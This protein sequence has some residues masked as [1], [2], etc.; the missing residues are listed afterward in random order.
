[1]KNLLII[2]LIFSCIPLFGQN[3]VGIPIDSIRAEF[4]ELGYQTNI[5][6]DSM[7]VLRIRLTEAFVVFQF[8]KYNVCD[9]TFIL[10]DSMDV[11]NK[12]IKKYNSKYTALTDSSWTAYGSEATFSIIIIHEPGRAVPYFSWFFKHEPNLDLDLIRE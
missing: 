2:V 4:D 11:V 1:M 12:L 10:P 9:H 5:N 8:D 3:R 6:S 7:P